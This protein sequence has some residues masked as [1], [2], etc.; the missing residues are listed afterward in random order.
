LAFR[1]GPIDPI[2]DKPVSQNDF[3]K[4]MRLPPSVFSKHLK[5]VAADDAAEPPPSMTAGAAAAAKA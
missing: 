1:K 2:T 4:R 3:A 5:K